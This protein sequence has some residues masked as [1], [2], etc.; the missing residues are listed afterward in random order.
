MAAYTEPE[1]AEE[2][3][4]RR[5]LQAVHRVR[6]LSSSLTRLEVRDFLFR[7]TVAR[8]KRPPLVIEGSAKMD[9]RQSRLQQSED[10]RPL[11]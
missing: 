8:Q 1:A 5:D 7:D 10:I 6:A 3:A 4:A 11:A 9:K 2:E